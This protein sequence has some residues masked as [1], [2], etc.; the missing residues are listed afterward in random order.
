MPEVTRAEFAAMCFCERNAINTYIGRKKINI[1]SNG[2]IDTDDTL[3]KIFL[4]K[5]KRLQEKKNTKTISLPIVEPTIKK[6]EKETP[7]VPTA[8]EKKQAKAEELFIN[9]DLYKRELAETRIKEL[10]STQ[11]QMEIDKMMGKLIPVDLVRGILKVNVQDIFRS[12]ENELMNLASIYCDIMAAGDRSKLSE[13]IGLMRENLHRII[14]ESKEN[15][16]KE[17]KSLINEY[18]ETR[19]RG[20]RK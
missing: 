5:R 20:E 18:S 1:L 17:I 6:P 14:K 11:K 13:V 4:K 15:S 10:T 8:K 16:A 2:Y 12:F 3:N 9:K 19:S 7:G